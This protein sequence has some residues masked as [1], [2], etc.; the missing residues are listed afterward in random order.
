MSLFDR[1]R[2]PCIN[3]LNIGDR[4][5][6]IVSPKCAQFLSLSLSSLLFLSSLLSVLRDL[7]SPDS[8]VRASIVYQQRSQD[9]T[10]EV[11]LDRDKSSSKARRGSRDPGA[12]SLDFASETNLKLAGTSRSLARSLAGT[13]RSPKR[14]S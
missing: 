4:V 7:H 8:L 9:H 1:K 10:R 11:S 5:H 2:R 14:R 12:E 3:F 13:S 6:D